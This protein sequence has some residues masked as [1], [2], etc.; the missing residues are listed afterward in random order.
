MKN[1]SRFMISVCGVALGTLLAISGGVF[2]GMAGLWTHFIFGFAQALIG[3]ASIVYCVHQAVT[4]GFA[5]FQSELHHSETQSVQLEDLK[6]NK[7]IDWKLEF[8]DFVHEYSFEKVIP[9]IVS[10]PEI[11]KN[12]YDPCIARLVS[13]LYKVGCEYGNLVYVHFEEEL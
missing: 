4:G 12:E 13:E 5:K 2:M 11:A 9:L 8:L 3:I 7:D 10:P 1:K 6:L